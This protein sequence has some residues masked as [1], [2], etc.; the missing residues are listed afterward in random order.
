MWEPGRAWGITRLWLL[1]RARVLG[2]QGLQIASR[3]QEGHQVSSPCRTVSL[4]GLQTHSSAQGPEEGYSDSRP[5][6]PPLTSRKS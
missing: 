3:A 5:A 2:E 1:G 4:L 6:V